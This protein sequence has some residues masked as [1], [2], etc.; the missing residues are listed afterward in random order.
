V[1]ESVPPSALDAQVDALMQRVASST[2]Q[3]CA[4]LRAEADSQALEILKSA[5]SDALARVRE[6]IAQ[7]RARLDQGVRRAQAQADLEAR[8]QAQQRL[9][10]LLAQMW[11]ALP[12]L[13]EARWRDPVQRRG[14]IEAAFDQAAALLPDRPWR[15]EHGAGW[16]ATEHAELETLARSKGASRVEWAAD[17]AIRAG[18]KVRAQGACLAATVDGLLARRADIESSF[19]A[20]YLGTHE[21]HGP[22]TA[23]SS[24]TAG[25]APGTGH[26]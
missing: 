12:G 6:A 3:R 10:E 26:P 13:L 19:L 16:S 23:E 1:T 25:S 2:A 5:R 11:Q 17:P 21:E 18:L 15:I 8:Q 9:E 4:S 24:T 14:W 20:R 7:E 22:G